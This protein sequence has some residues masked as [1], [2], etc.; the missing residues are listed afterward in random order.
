MGKKKLL[1]IVNNL[2]FFLTHRLPVAQAAVANGYEVS[3]AYGELGGAT[4]SVLEQSGINAF[5]VPMKRGGYNLLQ[6]ILSLYLVWRIFN[7]LR[8]DLIHLVTV[9]PYLYGG[10]VGRFTAVKSV[11]SA[12][13]GLGGFFNRENLASRVLRA[14]LLPLYKVAFGHPNQRVIVQNMNDAERLMRWGVV[15]SEK[16]CLLRGSGVNLAKFHHCDEPATLPVVCFAA[17]LVRDKG[18]FD[19]VSAARLLRKRAVEARFWLAGQPDSNNS[20]GLTDRELQRLRDEEVVEVLGFQNDIPA[21]YRQSHIICLPSFYGEGLPKSLLEGAA[22]GRAIVTTDHPGCRDAIVPNVSGLLVPVKC[23]E[24]LADALQWLI[25][26]P[27]ERVAMGR[28][29]RQL[30]EREFA[31]EKIVQRHMDIYRELLDNVT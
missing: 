22:A 31:I 5:Y 17:R 19:F 26:H 11:V 18:V 4:L 27:E 16:L 3:I 20:E 15:R 6:E 24:K 8:P 25:E 10:L 13:A 30:A 7:R 2:K 1:M 12:V 28:A 9:K 14:L 21:L 29:G 23:P